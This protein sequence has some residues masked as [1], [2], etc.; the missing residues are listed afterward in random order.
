MKTQGE[1]DYLHDKAR[2]EASE[3]SDVQNCETLHFCC[4]APQCVALCYGGPCKRVPSDLLIL[5]R[6]RRESK[7]VYFFRQRTE[8]TEALN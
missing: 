3:E 7:G 5:V 8:D 1:D 2:N 4:L 6:K